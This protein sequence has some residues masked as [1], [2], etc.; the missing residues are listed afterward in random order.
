MYN[1]LKGHENYEFVDVCL[2]ADNRLFIDPCL[3]E[4]AQDPWSINASKIMHSY[5]D[6]LFDELR[7]N[8]LQNSSLLDH[9]REQNA[10]K[11]GY[12]NGRNG[13]GKTAKGFWDSI[14]GLSILVHEIPTINLAQDL[15]VLVQNF[16]EDCMSDLLT[17]IL[18]DQLNS[19]TS[20]QMNLWGCPNQG[21]KTIWT[22]DPNSKSW[23]QV[24][25][26][27]WYYKG[28]ELL[29]VPKWIVRKNYLFN[30]EQYLSRVIIDHMRALDN[31]QN[32]KKIDII[33]NL[34]K[35]TPHWRYDTVISYSRKNPEVLTEYHHRMPKYYYRKNGK[36]S[37]EQLDAVVYKSY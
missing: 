28:K 14:K 12:G 8:N 25:R 34:P 23:I 6:C 36:M 35:K 2:D 1:T 22:F 31:S 21:Q 16:A 29:M 37:D 27:C 15:P 11:L 7:S 13:K 5:F 3:L 20:R 4:I 33:N 30:V 19:F 10:T 9:A 18:H 24:S 26:P 32:L 17:N